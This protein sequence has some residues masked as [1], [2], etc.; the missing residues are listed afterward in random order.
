[1]EFVFI[2]EN[3]IG[4]ILAKSF[5]NLTIINKGDRMNPDGVSGEGMVPEENNE[6]YNGPLSFITFHYEYSPE[7]ESVE[8]EVVELSLDISED[9]S[10][11][12]I[13]SKFFLFM[14]RLGIPDEILFLYFRTQDELSSKEDVEELVN[15]LKSRNKEM[16]VKEESSPKEDIWEK[17]EKSNT[18]P[19]NV[20]VF[21][22]QL[23]NSPD[24]CKKVYEIFMHSVVN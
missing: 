8:S 14:R 16:P 5:Q 3:C 19:R 13:M 12:R 7:L 21:R 17:V 9:D 15:N 18:P 11:D 20:Q 24:F 2:T 1:M 10:L 23:L 22:D 4:V 6:D